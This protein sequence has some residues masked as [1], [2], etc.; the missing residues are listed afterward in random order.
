VAGSDTR[1]SRADDDHPAV[2]VVLP[3]FD[4]APFVTRCLDSVRAQTLTDLE[5]LVI[6][7]CS[8]DGTLEVVEHW[9]AETDDPRFRLIRQPTNQGVA[10]ARNTALSQ[11]RGRYVAFVDSDDWYDPDFLAVLHERAEATGADVV[12]SGWRRPRP[13]GKILQ[14]VAPHRKSRYYVFQIG[15][16]W[17]KLHR[18]DFLR[19]H[20]VEFYTAN[21]F[22]EDLTFGAHELV[23]TDRIEF[24]DYI[25]Y[26]YFLNETSVSFHSHPQFGHQGRD[27]VAFL[28]HLLTLESR[29]GAATFDRDL[30]RY[31]SYRVFFSFLLLNGKHWTPDQFVSLTSRFDEFILKAHGPNALW[32]NRYLPWGGP[33]EPLMGRAMMV[34]VWSLHKLRL[35]SAFARFFCRGQQDALVFDDMSPTINAVPNH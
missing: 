14:T 27:P 11:A 19:R 20:Q 15:A 25:G 17:A 32:R 6:E 34:V 4:V 31:F 24:V 33:D 3:A 2:T 26:N 7:D 8:T 30:F 35:M 21:T 18:R 22:A 16:V 13:D 23:C 10:V 5:C 28:E 1:G 9:L 12:A 29:P